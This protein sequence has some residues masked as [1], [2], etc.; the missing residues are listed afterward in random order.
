MK[1]NNILEHAIVVYD[2]RRTKPC[3]QNMNSNNESKNKY[4]QASCER[5]AQVVEE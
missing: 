4:T 5:Y 1:T 2:N 3:I